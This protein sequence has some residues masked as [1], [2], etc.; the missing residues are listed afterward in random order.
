MLK[1]LINRYSL[2][3]LRYMKILVSIEDDLLQKIDKER[4]RL[5]LP[6]RSFLLSQIVRKHFKLPNI[7]EVGKK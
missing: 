2:I 4:E 1:R 6:S 7:F 5:G 3:S